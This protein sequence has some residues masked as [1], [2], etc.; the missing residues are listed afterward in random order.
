[1]NHPKDKHV[2]GLVKVGDKGQIVIPKEARV[3]FG[4]KPGDSLLML[5]DEQQG[6]A[7]VQ[8][9]RFME[10]T[11]LLFGAIDLPP[12]GEG[13]DK[14]CETDD[15]DKTDGGDA[16]QGDNTDGEGDK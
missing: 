6:L 9:K 3:V 8:S 12:D 15:T 16:A 4:I 2:F 7:L 11:Q 14:A 5:G 13:A 1:M 10:L